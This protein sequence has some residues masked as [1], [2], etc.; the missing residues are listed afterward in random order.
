MFKHR[1]ICISLPIFLVYLFSFCIF[2]CLF[3]HVTVQGLFLSFIFVYS[4]KF[5]SIFPNISFSTVLMI[6]VMLFK[7]V[8]PLR[9]LFLGGIILWDLFMSTVYLINLLLSVI[10][11][12][13]LLCE[14]YWASLIEFCIL[15]FLFRLRLMKRY[16]LLI[17]FY[18]FYNLFFFVEEKNCLLGHFLICF[19]FFEFLLARLHYKS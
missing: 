13:N 9:N 11:S 16:I 7:S 5:F 8:L 4:S 19:F 15:A 12:L 18:W 6:S 10:T 2:H 14:R 3:H 17:L 1:L